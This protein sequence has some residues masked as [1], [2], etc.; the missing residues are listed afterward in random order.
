MS[1]SNECT[2][3]SDPSDCPFSLY[4]VS[5]DINAH[6]SAV[7]ANLEYTLPFLGEGGVHA[8]YPQGA[9][10]RSRPGGWAYPDMLEVGN[11]ANATE[12]R[13]HFSAWAIMSSPLILSFNLTDP[14]R[15]GRAWPIISNKRVLAVNQKWAGDPGRR[16][17]LGAD[18]SQAWA[19]LLG[20]V[21]Y[22]VFLLNGGEQPQ[23]EVVLPLRNVSSA[24]GG[25][26]ACA[27]D[28]Y[29]G[30]PLPLIAAGAALRATL[31]AHDSGMYCV[32]PASGG[33]IG[34][35]RGACD[36]ANECPS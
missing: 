29:T 26:A 1:N 2:G 6:W 16:L 7:L 33:D 17:A 24:L 34:G 36:G 18:G 19:K 28:L 15:M 32:W 23:L 27:R 8:P 5:G 21:S 12:D 9:T 14:A 25:K 31:A 3:S 10:V 30:K 11:L 13:S 35:A 4:R 22:A 20:C